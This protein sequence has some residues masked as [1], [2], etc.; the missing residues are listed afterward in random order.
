[1]AIGDGNYTGNNENSRGG[2]MSDSTFYS[3]V[4]FK[5]DSKT[6]SINFRAGLLIFEI[7][8]YDKST[9]KTNPLISI[10]ISPT[11]AM[12]LANEINKFKEYLNGDKIKENVAF[13]VNAG[14]NEKVSYIGLHTNK[15][16]EVIVT[17][18]K[19]DGTGTIVESYD[20]TFQKNY[21]YSLEWSDITK[22]QLEKV[23]Q[24]NVEYEAFF[25]TVY[26]F[27]RYMN[28]A[29]GYAMV[30]LSRY[31]IGR[32]LTKMDPIY[33]KLGIERRTN[34]YN[35]GNNNF[36]NNAQSTSSNQKNFEEIQDLLG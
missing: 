28:G 32:V 4:R 27:A 14:M 13:G 23:Y 29:A 34:N 15:E 2:R 22:N 20:F 16:K 33:D 35:G 10:Y 1:M 17:I 24:D 11:K 7:G 5:N 3:R 6:L 9:Y 25:N 31:E 26:D 12:M 8:E 21:N 19:F 36:L 30:D 18:G